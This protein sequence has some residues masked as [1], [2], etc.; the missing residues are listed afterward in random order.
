MPQNVIVIGAGVVGS[1][2]A[3]RLA[4]EGANVLV[5]EA[6]RV[7][8]G[9]SG[10]SYAWTN[11]HRKPPRPYHALN[12][13]G[14]KTH[15][16]LRE[17]FPNADW[18]HGGGGLEWL[19]P[20]EYDIQR[21]NIEQLQSWGYRAEWITPKQVAE[22]EPDVDLAVLGDAPA[23]FFPDEGWLDPIPYCHAMLSA[24]IR[25]HGARLLVGTPVVGLDMAGDRVR[26]VRMADGAT[27][28]ADIVVNCAGR[29]LNE[30]AG[31]ADPHLPLAPTR[32]LLVF[33]PPVACGLSRVIHT[34][35]VNARPDG[36]GRLMLHWNDT[37]TTLT[38]DTV[39][40]PDMPQA[41]DLIAR[42]RRLFPGIGDV[43]AE[44]V[45]L[46]I[47]PIP[48]DGFT[49]VGPMPRIANYYVAITHSG[50]TMSPFLGVCVAD[51]IA[52]GRE[53]AELADFRPA[54]FFN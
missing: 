30:A 1:S 50:V 31:Q 13:N 41:V 28:G 34:S 17:E 20:E 7:G 26:G 51:E 53:R 35:V 49:A 32:G 54:R 36:A 5:L 29:W 43:K 11:A 23:A 16:A 44:A 14:M 6:S 19:P 38:A 47:R 33:T 4:R 27:H 39:I 18:W 2:C 37:D 42:A 3:Y 48:G 25:R 40:A 45:R 22:L 10:T 12:V 8:A 52:H 24:A 46:G 9:T 21:A 15:A